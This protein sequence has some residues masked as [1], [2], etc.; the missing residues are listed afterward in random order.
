MLSVHYV[1]HQKPIIVVAGSVVLKLR[2]QNQFVSEHERDTYVLP[3][4]STPVTCTKISNNH[5]NYD[6]SLSPRWFLLFQVV[7]KTF[8]HSL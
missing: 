5:I 8:A 2:C 7:S 3:F 1:V 4:I 6:S